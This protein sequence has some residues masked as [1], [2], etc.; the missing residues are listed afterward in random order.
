MEQLK[1]FIGSVPNFP[2]KDIVFKDISPLLANP[3]AFKSVIETFALNWNKKIDAIAGLD[4][5]G[6]IFGSALAFSL[7]VTFVMVR[8]RGKLPGATHQVSYGLEYGSDVIEIE[9]SA[10]VTGARVLI[11]DDLLATGGT[12]AAAASLIETA[13]AVVA[14]FA[15]VIELSELD[16]RKKIGNYSIDSLIVY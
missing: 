11:I 6:F 8:K 7:G 3:D 5:R 4:A 9:R 16:G 2:K 14:G 15:F 13:G 1:K 12:A 10:F